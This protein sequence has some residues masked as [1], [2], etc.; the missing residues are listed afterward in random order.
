MKG[1]KKKS[2]HL[3]IPGTEDKSTKIPNKYSAKQKLV[4]ISMIFAAKN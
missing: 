4:R 2:S 3:K 1:N